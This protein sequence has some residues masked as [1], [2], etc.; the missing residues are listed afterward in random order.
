MARTWSHHREHGGSTARLSTF[1]HKVAVFLVVALAVLLVGA[2]PAFAAPA[3]SGQSPTGTTASSRPTISVNIADPL[4]INKALTTMKVDNVSVLATFT[5]TTSDQK[6]ATL[7]YTPAADMSQAVH[8]VKVTSYNYSNQLGTTT[9]TFTVAAPPVLGSPTPAANSIVATQNPTIN[10]R[11]LGGYLGASATSTVDGIASPASV[12]ATGLVT[13]TRTGLANDTTHTVIVRATNSAGS[14]LITWQFKVQLYA[15]VPNTNCTMAGCHVGEPASHDTTTSA[16][17][18]KCHGAG[19]PIGGGYLISNS[20]THTATAKLNGMNCSTCHAVGMW[21]SVGVTMHATTGGAAHYTTQDSFSGNCSSCHTADLS[22]EHGRADLQSVAGTT[23]TWQRH[24]LTCSAC[25]DA[26][27]TGAS[28]WGHGVVTGSVFGV[29]QVTGAITGNI[30]TCAQCH[31]VFAKHPSI[32][33]PAGAQSAGCIGSTCHIYVVGADLEEMLGGDCLACHTSNN[34]IPAPIDCSQTGCHVAGTWNPPSS[35]GINHGH[36]VGVYDNQVCWDC[37]GVSG[38]AEISAVSTAGAWGN[39]AGDHETS[40][41]ASAHGENLV[42]WET[43]PSTSTMQCDVC[44]NHS[45]SNQ[46]WKTLMYRESGEPTPGAQYYAVCYKCHA[47][48][49]N[50]GSEPGAPNTYNGRD[51]RADFEKQFSVGGHLTNISH[52]WTELWS[53]FAYYDTWYADLITEPVQTNVQF[54]NDFGGEVILGY[55][56]S[57]PIDPP[58]QPLVFVAAGGSTARFDQYKPADN[59]WDLNNSAYF[60]PTASSINAQSGSV[61]FSLESTRTNKL[62]AVRGSGSSSSYMYSPPAGSGNGTWTVAASFSP[63]SSLGAGADAAVYDYTLPANCA[64]PTVFLTRA[65]GN[66]TVYAKSMEATPVTYTRSIYANGVSYSIGLGSAAEVA[67]SA[68]TY[69]RMF[70]IAKNGSSQVTGVTGK[71]LYYDFTSDADRRASNNMTMTIGPSVVAT[72]VNEPTR[73]KMFTVGGTNYLAVLGRNPAGILSLQ[74]VSD[75]GGTPTVTDIGQF[76]AGWTTVADGMALQFSD[77]ADPVVTGDGYLYATRGASQTSFAR[78][79]VP[80]SDPTVPGNWGTWTALTGYRNIGAGAGIGFLNADTAPYSKR[81]YS[82]GSIQSEDVAAPADSDVWKTASWTVSVPAGTGFNVDVQGYNVGTSTWDTLVT[83]ATTTV[84]LSSYTTAAY[85]HMRLIAHFSTS[86]PDNQAATPVMYDWSIVAATST[87][88]RDYSTASCESCHNTHRNTTGGT[89]A[90]QL[91]RVSNPLNINENGTEA[92]YTRWTDFCMVCHDTQSVVE[93]TTTASTLVPYTISFR[94]VTSRLF[95]GWNKNQSGVSWNNSGH[96]AGSLASIESSCFSQNYLD[97]WV[98]S[99][100]SQTATSSVN[101]GEAQLATDTTGGTNGP[102]ATLVFAKLGGAGT[103]DQYK[104]ADDSWNATNT[105]GWNPT[106][107]AL[108]PSAGS[109]A[110]RLP[111][112]AKIYVNSGSSVYQYTPPYEA[113]STVEAWASNSS[114]AGSVSGTGSDAAV[115]STGVAGAAGV[116]NGGLCIYYSRGGTS[117][118]QRI[119]W[120]GYQSPYS[121]S[122]FQIGYPGTTTSSMGG[123]GSAMAFSKALNRL[124]IINRNNSTASTG[125]GD[126]VLYYRDAPGRSTTTLTF[127]Q[128]PAITTSGTV[129]GQATTLYNRM[130]TVTKSSTDYLIFLGSSVDAST[131]LACT[132]VN[133]STL[134]TFAAPVPSWSTWGDGLDLEYN[135]ADG[136][137]YAQAGGNTSAFSRISVPA[138]PMSDW[139]TQGS[140]WSNLTGMRTRGS[141]STIQFADADPYFY[142]PFKYYASGTVT[143]KDVTPTAGATNWGRVAWSTTTPANTAVT[144]D[145]WGENSVSGWTLLFPGETLGTKSMAAYSTA[146]YPKLRLVANLS[147]TS[148]YSSTPQLN[149][150]SISS[151]V[152]TKYIR[153]DCNNCHDPHGSDN[154]GLVT[155]TSMDNV[156]EVRNNTSA[157]DGY[158]L[159][160]KCHGTGSGSV[161]G[162]LMDVQTPMQLGGYGHPVTLSSDEHSNVETW[163]AEAALRHIDCSDCHNSHSTRAG[164]HTPMTSVAG[165]VL[166]GIVGMK[167]EHYGSNWTTPAGPD[168]TQVTIK[169]DVA[170]DNLEAFVCYKCHAG[171]GVPYGQTV[172]TSSAPTGYIQVDVSQTFNPNNFSLHNVLGQAAGMKT[173]FNFEDTN[174]VQRTVTWALPTIGGGLNGEFVN[175]WQYNSVMTCTDCHTGGT[176]TNAYGPH[177]STAKWMLDPAYPGDWTNSYL[178]GSAATQGMTLVS[179]QKIICAKCHTLYT[180]TYVNGAH[181]GDS[182][183]RSSSVTCIKCHIAIPHGWKRPRLLVSGTMDS[184][185]YKDPRLTTTNGLNGVSSTK[186]HTLNS[187][188][189]PSWSESDCY[190]CNRS[191]HS[192]P[193]DGGMFP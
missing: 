60:A 18:P 19:S 180:T 142:V 68:S 131:T 190:A 106:S 41:T 9:W 181:G 26:A 7:S 169:P 110:F 156:T 89:A 105:E 62:F 176:T 36:E 189:V 75:L 91:D 129:T 112:D 155:Y 55:D 72:N 187:S 168:W 116:T 45:P 163:G 67:T 159:C 70:V 65:G 173:V 30:T 57:N 84:D 93:A 120:R 83:G 20:P 143:T 46:N 133:A 44:H 123:V 107:A 162:V 111:N 47:A 104:P 49:G 124:F 54:T 167:P 31:D 139:A 69:G 48:S 122:Y 160:F 127:T 95:T 22:A 81:Y 174:G 24:A 147:S 140:S 153:P 184:A 51:V 63:A 14:G 130:T 6:N 113:S 183:H 114:L 25:H 128:G 21:P 103:L 154:E 135:A 182:G 115:D 192:A 16:S 96:N 3:F 92:G 58:S 32:P 144:V 59:A 175:G 119:Y 191:G 165:E 90:W 185:P 148:I 99:N 97:E 79:Q 10:V 77:P 11:I 38:Q 33:H 164:K 121:S 66:A 13:V 172:I 50:G 76:P 125:G 178:T 150:W 28:E 80:A 64:S 179:G 166:R 61:F 132:V 145:I 186:T 88:V 101:N 87:Q 136:Y 4:R 40:F 2:I 149:D 108:S 29:S 39:T 43:S 188:G 158:G 35:L 15:P 23:T 74:V 126:G 109:N 17:C 27:G 157:V 53:D 134:A 151:A 118:N 161:N 73:M 141:G 102:A 8:T 138:D 171:E 137:L 34:A 193:L 86:D 12:S 117:S 52:V 37:H 100:Y 82:T 56:L 78:I 1:P 152:D 170:G 146:S 5:Y 85:D 71:L 94:T 42:S 98:G 177:G